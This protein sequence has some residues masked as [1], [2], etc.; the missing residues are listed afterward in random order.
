MVSVLLEFRRDAVF[1]RTLDLVDILDL[2]ANVAGK[3]VDYPA[4]CLEL[5]DQH[6][7]RGVVYIT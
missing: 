6:V 4:V 7:V 3:V 1:D 2:E 5:F